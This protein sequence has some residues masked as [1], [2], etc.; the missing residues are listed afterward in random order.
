MKPALGPAIALMALS[1]SG[2]AVDYGPIRHS[3]YVAFDRCKPIA[4]TQVDTSTRPLFLVTSRLPDCRSSD[5]ALLNHRSDQPELRFGYFAAPVEHG[6]LTKEAVAF[7]YKDDWWN[8]LRASG[9]RSGKVLLYV[10]GYNEPFAS[11]ATDVAQIRRMTRFIGPVIAYTWPSQHS[12]P[13]Y[14]AD[15]TNLNWDLQRFR[16]F[17]LK[18]AESEEIQEVIV[19][20]HSLGVRL[21]APGIEYVDERG[22]GGKFRKIIFAS[23]DIDREDFEQTFGKTLVPAARIEEGRRITVYASLNDKALALS[24]RVHGYPRLGSPF[25]FDPNEPGKVDA[26]SKSRRC[27]GGAAV[28]GLTLIDTTD[29]SHG[30]YGHSDYLRS[31]AACLD[32]IDVVNGMNSRSRRLGTYAS[33]AFR[34]AANSTSGTSCQRLK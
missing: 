17:L 28:S 21:A 22:Q 30:I 10:H 13:R 26:R 4:G 16:E 24:R 31:G 33:H 19:V 18:L 6:K 32:F 11:V 27:Y 12:T 34:L 3:A 5:I 20:T 29:I 25:C 23:P 7:S 9:K 14:G 15:E 1:L 2:C 8:A